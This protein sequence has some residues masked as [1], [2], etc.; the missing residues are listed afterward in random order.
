MEG[1]GLMTEKEMAGMTCEGREETTPQ[2]LTLYSLF[3]H[4]TGRLHHVLGEGNE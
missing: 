4:D 3:A 1:M 2:Q